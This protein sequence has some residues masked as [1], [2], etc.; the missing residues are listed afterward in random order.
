MDKNKIKHK[1]IK[2]NFSSLM[3]KSI[4]LDVDP[5]WSITH[6]KKELDK[7]GMNATYARRLNHCIENNKENKGVEYD[8]YGREVLD[9]TRC[10]ALKPHTLLK[11]ISK[12]EIK[13]DL[14]NS[15]PSNKNITSTQSTITQLTST[16][17]TSTQLNIKLI[18]RSIICTFTITIHFQLMTEYV[19]LRKY[20]WDKSLCVRVS[21]KETI[22]DLKNWLYNHLFINEYKA[23]ELHTYNYTN[24]YINPTP[25]NDTKCLDVFYNPSRSPC[26][27]LICRFSNSRVFNRVISNH[28]V[29]NDD[30]DR[31]WRLT[32]L[33]DEELERTKLLYQNNY[34]PFNEPRNN[35]SY[36]TSD[37]IPER[38]IEINRLKFVND[39]KIKDN[40]LTRTGVQLSYIYS[41]FTIQDKISL[42]NISRDFHDYYDFKWWTIADVSLFI[43]NNHAIP[44][45][46]EPG[47]YLFAGVDTSNDK[48]NTEKGSKIDAKMDGNIIDSKEGSKIDAKMGSKVDVRVSDRVYNKIFYLTDKPREKYVRDTKLTDDSKVVIVMF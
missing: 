12:F 14:N 26:E 30:T 23:I 15:V 19:D 16:Q 4:S 21:V 6:L 2:V 7:L 1:T 41:F 35:S 40:F 32:D 29:I 10:I 45:Y 27:D 42:G 17:S 18:S 46:R 34:H 8:N 37:I 31:Y 36:P 33:A 44:G 25:L 38:I 20:D 13:E 9:D 47:R 3:G 5:N 48:S 43:N 11:D 28:R 22:Q 39:Y 24:D